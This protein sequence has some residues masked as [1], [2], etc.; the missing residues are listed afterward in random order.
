M[1][2]LKILGRIPDRFYLL[3]A[4]SK[5]AFMSTMCETLSCSQWRLLY[6]NAILFINPKNI[7]REIR[8]K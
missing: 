4:N 2:H 5:L 6:G 1:I 8:W 3:L 7:S